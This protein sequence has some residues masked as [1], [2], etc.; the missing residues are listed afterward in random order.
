[1]EK[2]AIFMP[3]EETIVV[4]DLDNYG[5]SGDIANLQTDVTKDDVVVDIDEEIKN[6]MREDTEHAFDLLQNQTIPDLEDYIWDYDYV[7]GCNLDVIGSV[8]GDY[9]DLNYF[10]V[11]TCGQCCDEV[12]NYASEVTNKELKD[13]IMQIVAIWKKQDSKLSKEDHQKAENLFDKIN[14]LNGFAGLDKDEIADKVL[15]KLDESSNM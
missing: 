13:A 10:E 14:K 11:N 6:M 5:L 4:L 9:I 2:T 7:S 15:D 8:H 12:A 1:M 3:N